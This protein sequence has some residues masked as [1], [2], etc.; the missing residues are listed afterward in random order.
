MID[1]AEQVLRDLLQSRVAAL[2]GSLSQVGFEPPDDQWKG[3]V[4]A[5]GEER[6]NLYLHDVRENRSLRTNETRRVPQDGWFREE[7]PRP[8]LDCRY[9]VTAWSPAVAMP[10][11]VEPTRDEH[12]LL[13]DVAEVLLRHRALATAEVYEPMWS[14]PSNNTAASFPELAGDEL[15]LEVA[16]PDGGAG[17]AEFWSTMKVPSRP[18]LHVTVTVPVI[19]KRSEREFP[20]VTTVAADYLPVTA[21]AAV[22]RL[23][24]LGGRVMGGS[25]SGPVEGAWVRILGLAPPAVVAVSRRLTTGGDGRF[26][27]SRLPAG[28]YELR[29]VAAGLGVLPRQVV[30]PSETGEYD[31]TFP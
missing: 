17:F 2:G 16:V 27:F 12:R 23:H 18:A 26:V 6:L 25:P 11:L 13:A 14:F 19:L 4:T 30:V 9:L 24:T 22:E 3:A 7:P 15:P 10:P 21:A 8:R 28:Q 29:A 31:I 1:P 5:A 20:M